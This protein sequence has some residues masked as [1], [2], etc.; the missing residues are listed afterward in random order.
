MA[1]LGGAAI[2]PADTTRALAKSAHCL[3]RDWFI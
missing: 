2:A 3:D 1:G